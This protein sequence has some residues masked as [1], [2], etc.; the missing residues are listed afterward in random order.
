M[1]CEQ[2]GVPVAGLQAQ[3]CIGCR[4]PTGRSPTLIG[5]TLLLALS[6]SLLRALS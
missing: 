3:P 2:S 5:L 6:T 1:S 4:W